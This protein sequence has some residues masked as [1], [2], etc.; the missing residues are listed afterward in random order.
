MVI[1]L[2]V[3]GCGWAVKGEKVEKNITVES[4]AVNLEE[5]SSS[6]TLES[7]ETYATL[8]A[9]L[10]D[11]DAQK[12]ANALFQREVTLEHTK[13]GNEDSYTFSDSDS[14]TTFRYDVT[15]SKYLEVIFS[16]PFATR[17]NYVFRNFPKLEVMSETGDTTSFFEQNEDLSFLTAKEAEKKVR[18]LLTQCGLSLFE[19]AQVYTLSKESLKKTEEYLDALGEMND[20]RSGES[21]VK[22]NWT[23]EDECYYMIFRGK[24]E[25]LPVYQ[26]K[27]IGGE[28]DLSVGT[29]IYVLYSAEGIQ[30]LYI[31]NPYQVT[32]E[33]SQKQT[34]LSKAEALNQLNKM[35]GELLDYDRKTIEQCYLCYLPTFSS[36]GIVLKPVWYLEVHRKTEE[37]DVWE[38]Y[39]L[40]AISGEWIT[41]E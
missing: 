4:L 15:G 18:D 17:I 19:D 26:Y 11:I 14:D 7:T 35:F 20:V 21:L 1:V 29:R 36:D 23:S 27:R 37:M 38:G 22:G 3:S 34:I 30:D 25:N 16:T 28:E 13:D 9:T 2:V 41:E 32:Q 8:S 40:D 12:L 6:N 10:Q 24:A 31:E 5:N 39:Y 33:L